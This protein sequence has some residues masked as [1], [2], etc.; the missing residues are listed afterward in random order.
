MA[1]LVSR[2]ERSC[3]AA[4]SSLSSPPMITSQRVR[5][6]GI[7]ASGQGRGPNRSLPRGG[8]R[9]APALLTL[10]IRGFSASW[11]APVP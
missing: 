11:V 1:S 8:I 2:E 3:L 4:G 9:Q 5:S 6:A 10:L 7:A